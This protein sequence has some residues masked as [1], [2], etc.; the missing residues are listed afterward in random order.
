MS[1]HRRAMIRAGLLATV[2]PLFA[3]AQPVTA[4]PASAVTD[5]MAQELARRVAHVGD[6]TARFR[7]ATR[8]G[9]CGNG[10]RGIT[11]TDGGR[12]DDVVWGIREGWADNRC[13][14]GP[15]RVTLAVRGGTPSDVRLTVG[16]RGRDDD[17]EGSVDLGTVSAPA[18]AAYLL[19]LAARP[20]RPSS[21]QTILAAVVA[22]SSVVWPPLL[23]LAR[24]E[25][26]PRS[27]RR[28]A[29]FWVGHFACAAITTAQAVSSR[30]DTANRDVRK[31]VVFALSQR[32][33]AERVAT[34]TRVAQNDRDP[35]VRCTA[36][37]W[38]GQDG[39][40][41]E[42]DA[43]RTLRVFEGLCQVEVEGVASAPSPPEPPRPCPSAP[44]CTAGTASRAR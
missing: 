1:P 27:T 33:D 37:F 40:A 22:D 36:L 6:G 35:A 24:D 16:S 38:L 3:S 21:E 30:A 5:A 25:R 41:S 32:P 31:Q 2:I 23:R 42:G 9:V 29:T 12:G 15:A 18:A 7:Y 20:D 43:S 11:F 28:D 34:L 17:R 8:T 10:A 39:R 19:G 44:T 4:A 13:E 26:L 14:P